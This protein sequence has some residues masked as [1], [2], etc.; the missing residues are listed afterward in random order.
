MRHA[1]SHP[2]LLFTADELP[3]LRARLA[4]PVFAPRWRLF[5]RNARTMLKLPP[6]GIEKVRLALGV[7]GVSAFAY[8]VTGRKEFGARARRE[9]EA[10]L[11]AKSWHRDRGFN[12]GAE[13]PTSEAAQACAWVYDWCHDLF[14]AAEKRRFRR[15]LLELSTRVY[16]KSVEEYRDWWADN[17]VSNWC[18]VCHGGNGLGALAMYYEEEEARRAVSHALPA[19]LRFLRAM[20]LEDGDG[21]EGVM[22]HLYGE[23]FGHLFAIAA[24]RLFGGGAE[25]GRDATRKRSGYWI[26]YMKGPDQEYAN[27]NNMNEYTL[28]GVKGDE[29]G[30]PGALCAWYE[31]QTPG[32]DPLLRWCADRGGAAFYWRGVAPYW[33]LFR[34]DRPS[35]RTR[36][37]LAPAVLFRGAGHAILQSER[38]WVAYNGGW[39]SDS[40]HNNHDLGSFVLVSN[41]RRLLHDPGYGFKA[42]QEHS[43]FIV[44]KSDQVPGARGIFP[45]FGSGRGFHYLANELTGAYAYWLRRWVRHLVMV[46]GRYLVLLD[47]VAIA[48]RGR[49]DLE[50]RFQTRG[51]IRTDVKRKRAVIRVGPERLHIL[52]AAPHDAIVQKGKATL[53]FVQVTPFVRRREDI[54][55]T[56]LYPTSAGEGAPEAAFEARGATAKLTVRRPGG[57]RD[58]LV[59]RKRGGRWWLASVNGASAQGLPSGKKQT[60]FRV[61]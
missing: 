33:F 25:L 36:P 2:Y 44:A 61:R 54:F 27:F 3:A 16:L 20:N 22:Y 13:L 48:S 38:L 45:R 55:A 26:T 15:R 56:V 6:Y 59:F 4:R 21:H 60:V 42:A 24:A 51:A 41:G 12:H 32:G 10:L 34:S 31:S 11:G 57:R 37:K 29:R 50:V 1:P 43:T 18:G 39:T 46:D 7:C 35:V 17:P 5:L 52:A 23:I 28:A 40:S 19:E 30:P 47:D 58:V 49:V 8:A 9:A 53:E 14:A